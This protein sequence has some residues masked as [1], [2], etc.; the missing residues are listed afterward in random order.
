MIYSGSSYNLME[1]W[2]RIL[3]ILVKHIWIFLIMTKYIVVFTNKRSQAKVYT[4]YFGISSVQTI[5]T[6]LQQS[7]GSLL[8]HGSESTICSSAPLDLSPLWLSA[9]ESS[10]RNDSQTLSQAPLLSACG[11]LSLS[12]SSRDW[13]NSR[14]SVSTGQTPP[15]MTH[16]IRV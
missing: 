2:I 11:R 13:C 4:V 16:P 15:R 3:P 12:L 8:A 5:Y 9:A 1:F 6:Q 14:P 10:L 7:G